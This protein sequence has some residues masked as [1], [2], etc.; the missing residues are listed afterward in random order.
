MKLKDLKEIIP[1][2]EFVTIRLNEDESEKAGKWFQFRELKNKIDKIEDNY[3]AGGGLL[4]TI[5]PEE[6]E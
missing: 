5:Y 6:K 1:F 3:F 2:D 4:I